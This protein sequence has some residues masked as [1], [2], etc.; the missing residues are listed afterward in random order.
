MSST[1]VPQEEQNMEHLP[2]YSERLKELGIV[3]PEEE[4][5]SVEPHSWRCWEGRARLF[6]VVSDKMQ[7]IGL[8]SSLIS[9]KKEQRTH[10]S[11][12]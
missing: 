9:G 12:L 3:Q 4:T 6:K 8:G 5:A 7:K 1:E 10:S 11:A 2:S